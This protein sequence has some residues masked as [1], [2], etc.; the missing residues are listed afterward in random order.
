MSLCLESAEEGVEVAALERRR[1]GGIRHRASGGFGGRRLR[2]PGLL[3]GLLVFA[4]WAGGPVDVGGGGQEAAALK[5]SRLVNLAFLSLVP[6]TPTSLSLS[7]VALSQ[8]TTS[9]NFLATP[10]EPTATTATKCQATPFLLQPT[11]H[12]L[13]PRTARPT[14]PV[15]PPPTSLFSLLD[16]KHLGTTGV[17]RERGMTFLTT[18]RCVRPLPLAGCEP[19]TGVR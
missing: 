16:P 4:D 2:S 14:K 11:S 6:N 1:D 5:S 12:Q 10:L 15:P 8:R 7:S 19:L 3:A 9:P 13:S 18:S 17:A